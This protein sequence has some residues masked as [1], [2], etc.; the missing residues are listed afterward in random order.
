MHN[1]CYMYIPS[2]SPN[3]K[4]EDT[5]KITSVDMWRPTHNTPIY[6]FQEWLT[7][8]YGDMIMTVSWPILTL[9]P[10]EIPTMRAWKYSTLSEMLSSIIP[11]RI[12]VD[13]A[14][15]AHGWYISISESSLNEGDIVVHCTGVIFRVCRQQQKNEWMCVAMYIS[16]DACVIR[17]HTK[18]NHKQHEVHNACH[19]C[20]VCRTH[21]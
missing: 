13:T 16:N 19:L 6:C 8:T 2:S 20:M 7:V 3:Q 1:H 18:M 5:Q 10:S 9:N 4:I 15:L 12:G 11:M 21:Q 14:I 17:A